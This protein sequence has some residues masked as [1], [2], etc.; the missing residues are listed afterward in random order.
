MDGSA[1]RGKPNELFLDPIAAS[2]FKGRKIPPR[3]FVDGFELF[4]VKETSF[5]SGIGGIGKTTIALQL[6][7][8]VAMPVAIAETTHFLGRPVSKRGPVLFFSAEDDEIEI[9]R[10]LEDVAAAELFDIGHLGK[11]LIYDF[12][13]R[14][15]KAMLES[16]KARV[17]S[18]TPLFK[19]F[20]KDV[21]QHK[22]ALVILDNRAQ[23][24]DADELQRGIATKAI[25]TFNAYA[26]AMETTFVML[27]HPSLT[28]VNQKTGASGSTGWVNTGRANIHMTYADDEEGTDKPDDGRRVLHVQKGNLTQAGRKIN[29]QRD[30][31]CYHCT[32]Q[33]PKPGADI[34]QGSKA[35]RVFME[36]MRLYRQRG[37]ILTANAASPTTFAPK[38]FFTNERTNRQGLTMEQLRTAMFALLDKGALRQREDGKGT[39]AKLVLEIAEEA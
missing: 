32:D 13:T 30:C 9:Q 26:K 35:E 17:L 25:G 19:A 15:A 20:I 7:A 3:Q 24:V 11:L 2:S 6:A 38:V 28:G 21:E 10:K 36:L 1:F 18:E 5:L 22:P 23:V 39:R 34:G 14:L 37:I 4:P 29:L 33:P 31:G 12:S 8:A 27:A 16:R